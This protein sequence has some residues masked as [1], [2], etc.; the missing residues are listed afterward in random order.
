MREKRQAT[1]QIISSKQQPSA[2]SI[3]E[4]RKRLQAQ[5]DLLVKQKQD[6]RE[7]EL[8]DFNVKTTNKEDLHSE[9]MEMDKKMKAKDQS[10]KQ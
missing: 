1:E 8:G 4:R 9:L 10:S 6:K 2:E 3:E 7:K 5:R